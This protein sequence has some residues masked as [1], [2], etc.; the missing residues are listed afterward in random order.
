MLY[1]FTTF[2]LSAYL[3]RT[4]IGLYR[5]TNLACIEVYY[6]FKQQQ[7][8]VALSITREDAGFHMESHHAQPP[9]WHLTENH[10]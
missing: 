8:F 6:L 4:W 3:R 1:H 5:D 9:T 10:D 7:S 2:T